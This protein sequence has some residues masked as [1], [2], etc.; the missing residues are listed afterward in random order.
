MVKSSNAT[1]STLNTHLLHFPGKM[2]SKAN[3]P[4]VAQLKKAYFRV[5]TRAPNILKSRDGVA[6]PPQSIASI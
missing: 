4:G 6:L 5:R 2:N 3:T 1:T